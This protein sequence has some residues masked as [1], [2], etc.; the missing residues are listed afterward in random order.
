MSTDPSWYQGII[1]IFSP[2]ST[3]GRAQFV[4]IFNTL[5]VAA[6]VDQEERVQDEGILS[7]HD[8]GRGDPAMIRGDLNPVRGFC[9]SDGRNCRDGLAQE[10][11]KR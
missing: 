9:P 10:G 4:S 6:K 5:V 7:R 3:L 8:L 2:Q 1:P 11:N